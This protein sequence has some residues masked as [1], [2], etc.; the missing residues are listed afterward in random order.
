MRLHLQFFTLFPYTTLFR[1]IIEPSHEVLGTMLL[2]VR[3]AEA[4]REF[5]RALVLAPGRSRAL[6]GLA[7]SAIAGG[8]KPAAAAAMDRL[9]LNWRRADPKVRDAV[10]PLRHLVDRMP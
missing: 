7:R 5:E 3:P 2:A 1:S 8:D 6:I 4:R 9:G 10:L